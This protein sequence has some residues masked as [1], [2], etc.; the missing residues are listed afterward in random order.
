ML[1]VDDF[2]T[3]TRVMK[4]L[5]HRIGFEHV[6][7]CHDGA[8][9]LELLRAGQYGLVLCD[10]EMQPVNGTEFARRARAELCGRPCII[11]LTTASRESATKAVRDGMHAFVD[12]FILKP[13][14][15]DDLKAK[16]MEIAARVAGGQNSVG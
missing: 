14:N 13:F 15:S 12:G 8:S 6:D 7:V 9:A 16:L 1:V 11:L 4:T 3:M 5:A 10:L 2:V